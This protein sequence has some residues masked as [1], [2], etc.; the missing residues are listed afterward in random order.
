MMKVN[1]DNKEK[2]NKM[3]RFLGKLFDEINSQDAV[4]NG[5]FM[6]FVDEQNLQKMK[7]QTVSLF[8]DS[9]GSRIFDE[10]TY[11]FSFLSPEYG[12]NLSGDGFM[13]F[14]FE[15]DIVQEIIEQEISKE[16]SEL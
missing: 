2:I 6:D 9:L 10:L 3:L 5:A 14:P 16:E 12:F 15:E 4:F 7:E 13:Y 11:Y 8:G 1:V